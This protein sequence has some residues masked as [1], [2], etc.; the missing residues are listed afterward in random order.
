[1]RLALELAVIAILLGFNAILAASELALV[2]ARKS[3]LRALA[4]D[5]NRAARRV[6]AIQE[7]PTRFLAAVQVGITLAGFFAS[8]VATTA[9]AFACGAVNHLQSR[10]LRPDKGRQCFFSSRTTKP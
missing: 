8:A 1:M 7:E 4:D 5:G 2:S 3:R 6:L 10:W 9:S